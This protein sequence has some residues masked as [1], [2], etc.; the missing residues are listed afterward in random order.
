MERTLDIAIA[1]VLSALFVIPCLIISLTII[2]TSQG[3]VIYWSKRVGKNDKFFMMPKFRTMKEG[4]PPLATQLVTNP[5]DYLTKIGSFLRNTSLDEVPQLYSIIGGKMTFVGPR[6]ALFNQEDLIE[7]RKNN[8]VN[9]IKPGI[10]GWAQV[11]GRDDLTVREKVNFDS[12]YLDRK[13]FSFDIYIIWLTLLR[14]L[15]RDGVSH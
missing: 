6:P 15:K 8:G 10:T 9:T 5:D 2:L 4:V 11:N 1:I 3:P 14:V 13:S 12:E 7:L